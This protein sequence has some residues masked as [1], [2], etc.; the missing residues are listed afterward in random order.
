[1]IVYLFINKDISKQ[2]GDIKSFGLDK[3]GITVQNTN[4]LSVEMYFSS[5]N[6]FQP[7]TT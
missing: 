1:L 3:V 4:A 6:I 7:Q 5:L 2:N